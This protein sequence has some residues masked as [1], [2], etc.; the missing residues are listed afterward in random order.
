MNTQDDYELFLSRCE[1][2]ELLPTHT[3]PTL[4]QL[5]E[6][7]V[8]ITKDFNANIVARQCKLNEEY[9]G[10]L[11]EIYSVSACRMINPES[12]EIVV[13]LKVRCVVK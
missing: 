8:K 4:E 1:G 11:N 10:L 2:V 6:Y 5:N 3:I 13:A 12:Y 9:L 7:G